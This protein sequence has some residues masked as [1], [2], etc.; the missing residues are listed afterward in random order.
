MAGLTCLARATSPVYLV[1]VFGP[2]M[3]ADAVEQRA[4]LKGLLRAYAI[5][6]LSLVALAGWFYAANLEYLYYYYFVWNSDANAHLPLGQSFGH[7]RLLFVQNIGRP[8]MLFLGFSLVLGAIWQLRLGRPLWK[9]INWRALWCGVAPLAFLVL[10][11]TGLNPFVSMICA[12]GFLVFCE[13][14][15]VPIYARRPRWMEAA[16]IMGSVGVTLTTA[17]TGI[18]YH[19]DDRFV[20]SWIPRSAAIAAIDDQLMADLARRPPASY[21]YSLVHLGSMNSDVVL[22]SLV[23]DRHL[24]FGTNGTVSNGHWTLGPFGAA[25]TV[26]TEVQW[27]AVPGASDADKL[28]GLARSLL[29]E[30][31][32]L[33]LPTPNSVLPTQVYINAYSLRLRQLVLNSGQ[34]TPLGGAIAVAPGESVEWYRNDRRK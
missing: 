28:N 33:L 13:A 20:W 25:Q 19:T 1:L 23:F 34:L 14:P 2:L 4:S 7:A 26:S 11:G 17:A 24:D 21:S 32:Y 22:S 18:A 15:W 31:D 9:N 10:R 16:L 27:E 6:A 5:A 8:Q 30:S 29:Q 3:I 12:S